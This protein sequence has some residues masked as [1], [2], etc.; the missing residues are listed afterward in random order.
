MEQFLVE[1]DAFDKAFGTI[2][3]DNFGTPK[4]AVM[5][6][7]RH[8]NTFMRP[9]NSTT[10]ESLDAVSI[11]HLHKIHPSFA[12]NTQAMTDLVEMLNECIEKVKND[13]KYK[14]LLRNR[15]A[16]LPEI[17]LHTG[18]AQGRLA[19]EDMT[20][21]VLEIYVVRPYIALIKYLFQISTTLPNRKL[22]VVPRDFQFN[23]PAIYGKILNKQND[24]RRLRH[25]EKRLRVGP[26]PAQRQSQRRSHGWCRNPEA[27]RLRLWI[28][29]VKMGEKLGVS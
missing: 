9:H 28:R 18:R 27:P 4:S 15:P 2:V 19:T 12:D 7:L 29:G 6:T 17:M 1:K 8:V 13:N 25:A 14:T 26:L 20:S 23:H 5:P 24:Y 21:D 10:W 22:Q 11:A 3:P 16:T